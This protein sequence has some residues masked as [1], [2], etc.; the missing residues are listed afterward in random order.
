MQKHYTYKQ[1]HVILTPWER[2][3]LD[4]KTLPLLETLDL[5][6]RQNLSASQCLK[7]YRTLFLSK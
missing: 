2:L 5:S 4:T 1:I 3:N 6:F 7:T